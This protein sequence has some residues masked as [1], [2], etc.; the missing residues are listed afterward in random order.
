MAR[1]PASNNDEQPAAETQSFRVLWQVKRNGETTPPDDL[2]EL[3]R[4]GYEEL[5]STGVLIGSWSDPVPAAA[6]GGAGGDTAT[7]AT[8]AGNDSTNTGG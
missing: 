7:A 2:I 6:A 1:K 8:G 3:D 5:E 4:D